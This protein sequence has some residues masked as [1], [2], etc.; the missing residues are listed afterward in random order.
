VTRARLLAAVTAM[1]LSAGAASAI[2]FQ[3]G[4]PVRSTGGFGEDSCRGCHFGGAGNDPAGSALLTGLPDSFTPGDTY[5]LVL[6][7][8]HPHLAVAGFQLAIRHAEGGTQ[9][10]S[11]EIPADERGRIDISES[12]DVMFV[13]H[14]LDGSSLDR[15]GHGRWAIRWTA[16]QSVAP[17]VVHVAAVAGDGDASQVG[18]HVYTLEKSAEPLATSA[19]GCCARSSYAESPSDH[20]GCARC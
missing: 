16:P 2:A 6:T 3:D 19:D 13:H 17:I 4:P 5:A 15:H 9:A 11:F 8:E 12:R 7:I 10:G 1:A 18:D 20:R 14:S